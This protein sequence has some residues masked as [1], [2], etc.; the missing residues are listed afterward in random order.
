MTTPTS[1]IVECPICKD[2]TL[3]Q[4]LSGKLAG[5][6]ANVLDSTVKCRSCGRVHHV[7]LKGE[8]PIS[9][10]VVVS[11]LKESKRES[12]ILG[13]DEVLSVNDEVMCADLPVLVT[14][15]ESKAG[16]RAD[17]C[18]VRDISTIWAKRFDK[19]KILF[20]INHH[21][22]TYPEQMIVSPDEEFF[23]GD[24]LR[25]GNRDVVIHAIKIQGKSV[26][27]GGAAA[28][29]VVRIYANIVRKTT[30]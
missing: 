15:I 13:P 23:V 6:N 17:V 16:A 1:I 14:S 27:K 21:G 9:V 2:E 12:I 29:D 22:K 25:V 10:P 26:R 24:M 8:K 28:R 4:V 18:K 11:W 30:Y 20:S 3:H 7:V 19:V 5:K